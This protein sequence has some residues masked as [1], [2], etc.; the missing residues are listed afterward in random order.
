MT[1]WSYK[2]ERGESFNAPTML[3]KS[4]ED[5]W[6]LVGFQYV[7]MVGSEMVTFIFKRPTFAS[8]ED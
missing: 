1:K 4:G 8:H 7:S 6:E 3:A 2:I 5:G